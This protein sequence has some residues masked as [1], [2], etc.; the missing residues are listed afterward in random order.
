METD[1][2]LEQ[3]DSLKT[4]YDSAGAAALHAFGA[5][6]TSMSSYIALYAAWWAA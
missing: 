1:G 6:G 4:A 5:S 2:T 3:A